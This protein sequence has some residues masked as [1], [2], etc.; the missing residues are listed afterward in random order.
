MIRALFELARE[1]VYVVLAT[2]SVNILKWIQVH[3]KNSPDDKN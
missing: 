1:G 3:A 2:H